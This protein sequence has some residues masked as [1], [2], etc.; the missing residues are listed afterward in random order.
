[1]FSF[2]LF[3]Q[4]TTRILRLF[5]AKRHTNHDTLS[6]STTQTKSI[7]DT[8]HLCFPI[9]EQIHHEVLSLP[10]SPVLSIDEVDFIIKVINQY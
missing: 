4:K 8:N 10:M 9:T 6:C 3:E 7:A 2:S 1:M 5:V